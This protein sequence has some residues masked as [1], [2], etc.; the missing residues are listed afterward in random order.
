[1][2]K[3]SY[4]FALLSATG[5][6]VAFAP[7]AHA[8]TLYGTFTN[9]NAGYDETFQLQSNGGV[10]DADP[11]YT[12][13]ALTNDSMGNTLAIVGDNTTGFKAAGGDDVDSYFGT[14]LAGSSPFTNQTYD[15]FKPAFYSGAGPGVLQPGIYEGDFLLLPEPDVSPSLAVTPDIPAL[16]DGFQLVLS[17]VP[18]PD[19]WALLIAG[20][21][22]VGSALRASRK[23]GL[24]AA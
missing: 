7:A 11:S 15:S 20:A 18:E 3:I 22:I 24:V 1:M 17:A 6:A 19:A 9:I 4:A 2:N 10:L 8:V 23:R 21:A 14:G 12:D 13:F 5:G 16:N